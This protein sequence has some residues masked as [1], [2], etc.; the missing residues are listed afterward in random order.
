MATYITDDG[1][2]LRVTDFS[3][4]SQIV[5]MF[6]RGHGLVPLIAKGAKRASK[7][8]VMSGPLDLLTGGEAVFVP[9]KEGGGGVGGGVQLGT[10]AAWELSDHRSALRRYLPGLNAAMMAAEVTTHLL[11]PLDP[12]PQLFDE[13]QAAL[14]LL[15]AA[16]DARSCGRVLVAYV[17]AALVAAGYWPQLETCLACAKPV[18]DRPMRFDVRAGG[19]L[20]AG[21]G[22]GCQVARGGGV[23]MVVPGRVVAA[24]ERL[25]LPAAMREKQPERAADVGALRVALEMELAQIEAVTDKA[26]RTRDV[27]QGIF[28]A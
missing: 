21:N 28:T 18:A 10:L 20:C 2:C 9:A 7:K 4:T 19:V 1:I 16:R 5:G 14:E 12:H 22:Q 27:V 3:E 23:T 13:L 8:N 26:F 17:K 25:P 15:G 6:T 11:Q 24:L